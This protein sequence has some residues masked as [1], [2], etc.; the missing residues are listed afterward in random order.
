MGRRTTLLVYS[1]ATLALLAGAPSTHAGA[2]GGI[3][4][5]PPP[6]SGPGSLA[7]PFA[8][9]VEEIIDNPATPG[10]K[11]HLFHPTGE[12][13]PEKAPVVLFAHGFGA[14]GPDPYR[15]WLEHMAKR[16]CL[17][18]Y[19]V[20]AAIEAPGGTSRYDTL[21]GGFEEGVRHFA[22]TGGPKPDL[23]R[24][25]VVGHSFG[26]GAA[27]ALAARAAIRGYG[28]K[29]LYVECWAPWFDLDRD[30]WTSLPATA[31]LLVG[32]FD[33]D[34]VC[35]PGMG[36]KFPARAVNVPAE[37][38]AFRCLRSDDHGRP[39]LQA[40]HLTPLCPKEA[41]A[42]DTRGIWRLDDALFD[43][44]VKG[45]ET[46]GATVFGQGAESL[47]LGTWS[48]GTP[49]APAACS[50]PDDPP[51]RTRGPRAMYRENPLLERGLRTLFGAESYSSLPLP[52][53]TLVRAT[54]LLRAERFIADPP[55]APTTSPDRS[56]L[57]LAPSARISAEVLERWKSAGIDV[58]VPKD[59]DEFAKTL[60][61]SDHPTAL[62]VGRDRKP[63]LWKRADDPNL[64]DAVL[65]L[66]A[67]P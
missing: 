64:V 10:K 20:Y 23:E 37:R 17:V 50:V 11:I 29:G 52:P 42:L 58:V 40:N 38:K 15:L 31:H 19:P 45:V 12:G 3:R 41:D 14:T 47:S 39:A 61:K 60:R 43:F 55:E 63:L 8:G 21:W 24:L 13:L 62:L 32:T 28:S 4:P 1:I 67:K 54:H 18:I 6:T 65:D 48:D 5:P 59:G 26:G 34:L 56:T 27:P 53:P 51:G 30:A 49:V 33:C 25:G 36:A 7:T 46:A 35:D 16:G 9:V 2:E 44:A 66:V 57:F 22:S